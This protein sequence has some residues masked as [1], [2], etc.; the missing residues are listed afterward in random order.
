MVLDNEDNMLLTPLALNTWDRADASYPARAYFMSDIYGD[1]YDMSIWVR[2]ETSV[3]DNE[4]MVFHVP[5][6]PRMKFYLTPGCSYTFEGSATQQHIM[7]PCAIEN[8]VVRNTYPYPHDAPDRFK[9]LTNSSG[10]KSWYDLRWYFI[11]GPGDSF[12]QNEMIN[13]ALMNHIGY[14]IDN[15]QIVNTFNSLIKGGHDASSIFSIEH[16]ASADGPS[17]NFDKRVGIV[18]KTSPLLEEPAAV[19]RFF[20]L[21]DEKLSE[22]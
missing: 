19:D 5:E 7:V 21:F 15:W 16:S 13:F 14:A 8:D 17:V 22:A 20:L 2:Q 9:L 6:R 1:A 10:Y 12:V 3:T 18:D 4:T 11:D